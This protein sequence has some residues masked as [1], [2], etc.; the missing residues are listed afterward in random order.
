MLRGAR[1]LTAV[2]RVGA[3]STG[4]RWG[5]KELAGRVLGSRGEQRFVMWHGSPDPCFAGHGS[6]D[7]SHFGRGCTSLGDIP[8]SHPASMRSRHGPQRSGLGLC[9]T[10]CEERIASFPGQVESGCAERTAHA[11]FGELGGVHRVVE[12]PRTV[13]VPK[14]MIRVLRVDADPE[15]RDEGGGGGHDA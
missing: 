6:G 4:G 7:P 15:E 9:P 8:V 5:S 12:E 1:H 10:M 2:R 13:V 14:M 3:V 11:L